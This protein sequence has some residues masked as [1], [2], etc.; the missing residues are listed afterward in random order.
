MVLENILDP[1][2]QI[3]WQNFE[4]EL[5][6]TVEI[7]LILQKRA[8]AFVQPLKDDSGM[9]WIPPQGG[10]EE[11]ETILSSARRE[12]REEL[13]SLQRPHHKADFRVLWSEGLYLGSAENKS[14]RSGRP[15]LI[16]CVAFPVVH[17]NLCVDYE[18]C[19]AAQWVYDPDTVKA[20][21]EPTRQ[22]NVTKYNIICS[23][24]LEAMKSQ[25]LV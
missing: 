17:P 13:P 2:K 1:N 6:Q 19:R 5:R 12:T 8:V 10:C 21:L 16:H 9:V 3:P 14:A 25:M 20:I 11:K 15:K 23:A 18:E 4:D 7:L 24:I 22:E